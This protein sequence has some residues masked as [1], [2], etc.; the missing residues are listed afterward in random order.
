M[1]RII[2]CLTQEHNYWLVGVAAMVCVVGSCLTVRLTTRLVQASN[3]RWLVQLVLTSLMGGT[4]IWSTHFIAMVAYEPGIRHAYEPVMTGL[5]LGVAFI[6]MFA[7]NAV[8]AFAPRKPFTI[9]A[10]VL[11]GLTVSA[12]HYVGMQAY[13]IPGQLIWNAGSVLMSITFGVSLGICAY[14]RVIRPITR[15]CWL[16]GSVFMILAICAMH[17]T[18]MSAF[19]I[20][21]DPVV[22]VPPRA[23]SDTALSIA[24]MS[25]MAVILLIGFA[26][27]SIE[28]NLEHEA[29]AQLKHVVRHDALTGIPNRYGLT[30]KLAEL[31]GT[32]EADNTAKLGV[33]TIDL[34]LFKEV[35][36]LYGH[37]TGD[38]VLITISERMQG[39]LGDGE[40]LAR[41][42]GDEFVALKT[43]FRRLDE[44]VAFAERLSAVV[45][46]PIVVG[47]ISTTVGASIG[48][49]TTIDDGRDF[50]ELQKKS[51]VAMYRA[52]AEPELKIC[53]YNAEMDKQSQDKL[54]M[55]Q[56]LRCAAA[57]DE[58][59]LVYQLQNDVNSLEPIGFEALLRWNNPTLGRV[60]PGEFI[61]IAEET[62]LIREIGI[63]VLRTACH[64][65]MR[66]PKDYGI[67]VNVAP[68]Q[69][70]QPAFLEHV[71]DILM[72]S[73]LPPERLELEIT[74]AS[75]ID[76]QVHT[77]KIMHKLKAM[78]I[79]IAMDD[80]G[81]G[82]SSLATLQAFP[83]DKIKI[84]RSFVQDVHFN[85]QR[86]AIVRS[87]LL[88][89]AALKI[90][91]LAEGVE[92][93]GELA[94]LRSENC[95]SVQGFYFGKPMNLDQVKEMM[96]NRLRKTG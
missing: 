1:Y 79:R 56:Q 71:S 62:G 61:P 45:I 29:R 19:R 78:G 92:F 64:E 57:N 38:T 76:D 59:E 43:E 55:I 41:T 69:L 10:G 91:V 85:E 37:A 53:V 28:T 24:V 40:F 60:S 83:F 88:L 48:I 15:Y 82:Y 2:E 20:Q 11:F 4:T 21:L 80:F 54:L 67:A 73:R 94:F 22:F 77:L 81:T 5:S 46:E 18:G 6:G 12:M 17:F 75:I 47:N 27:V 65:A 31:S 9:F 51:D 7:S 89:G 86:A 90:P 42:G 8:L 14:H 84:D 58:F 52:K 13:Q 95:T 50:Q 70:I 23:I 34:N 36:D 30:K 87:T 25:V 93:E 26:S 74:E 49:A 16:G 39:V 72:E 63:W 66:W 32:L 3:G 33:L 96:E 44:V 68:Q 35:N